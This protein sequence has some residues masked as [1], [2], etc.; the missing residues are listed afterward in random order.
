MDNRGTRATAS[1]SRSERS[2][3]SSRAM[4]ARLPPILVACALL[5]VA[6]GGGDPCRT[7]EAG[8]ADQC[9]RLNQVQVLGTHNS[10]HRQPTSALRTALDSIAPGWDP[11]WWY[12]H[13]PLVEQLDEL[14]IRQ[15]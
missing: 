11:E 1:T 8:N 2:T 13:P 9:L 3:P 10:Y 5:P 7:L 6:C 15:L 12:T 14:N 4:V